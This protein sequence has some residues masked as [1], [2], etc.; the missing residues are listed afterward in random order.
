MNTSFNKD[1]K[2]IGDAAQKNSFLAAQRSTRSP[3]LT[4]EDDFVT[5]NSAP[6]LEGEAVY[7]SMDCHGVLQFSLTHSGPFELFTAS[8]LG[9]LVLYFTTS[10]WIQIS[11]D[12]TTL[13]P[14]VKKKSRHP[15]R[16]SVSSHK[17]HHDR[18]R[19]NKTSVRSDCC[20]VAPCKSGKSKKVS[21]CHKVPRN[22]K[23]RLNPPP[24]MHKSLALVTTW[25][26]PELQQ[27]GRNQYQNINILSGVHHIVIAH[28]HCA[29]KTKKPWGFNSQ[30]VSPNE[31]VLT[32]WHSQH[33]EKLLIY[34]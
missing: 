26:L 17:G 29:K 7:G 12:F 22:L 2:C 19:T 25:Q 30:I 28:C 4:T 18:I 23:F 11:T 16:H 10:E 9:L 15:T 34:C 21:S 5:F 3:T 14:H 31:E 32:L 6:L 24:L 33:L 27:Y 13:P 20:Y 8:Y 1:S